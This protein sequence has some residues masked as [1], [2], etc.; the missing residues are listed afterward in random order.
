MIKQTSPQPITNG[1]CHR[2]VIQ[3]S[4]KNLSVRIATHN[5]KTNLT[6]PHGVSF[7]TNEPVPGGTKLLAD[8]EVVKYSVYY[9]FAYTFAGQL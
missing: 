4:Y 1:V 8:T 6:P 5:N 2:E 3:N 7:L 9:C